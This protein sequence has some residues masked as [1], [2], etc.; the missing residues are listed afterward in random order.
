MAVSPPPG[1]Q[2]PVSLG[3]SGP[4]AA[5][6]TGSPAGPRPAPRAAQR[7]AP[8]RHR[9]GLSTG[10]QAPCRRLGPIRHRAPAGSGVTRFRGRGSEQPRRSLRPRARKRPS[11]RYSPGGGEELMLPSVPARRGLEGPSHGS[12]S[13]YRRLASPLREAL[14]TRRRPVP[15]GPVGRGW[16]PLR[17][18][19]PRA[20]RGVRPGH[21]R[22]PPEGSSLF[23]AARP[24]RRLR[25]PREVGFSL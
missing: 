9:P 3:S 16:P 8:A 10:P 19:G 22:R 15:R 18:R 25:F 2:R 20:S 23:W 6:A 5:P 14:R 1:A 24:P 21:D 4:D 12:A 11:A 17:A 7:R 13:G